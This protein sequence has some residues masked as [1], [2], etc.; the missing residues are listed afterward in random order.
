MDELTQ[1]ARRIVRNRLGS[2]LEEKASDALV[3]Q[4]ASQISSPALAGVESV[5]PLAGS[6]I[7]LRREQEIHEEVRDV[8]EH[9]RHRSGFPQMRELLEQF[10]DLP[11][12]GER[13]IGGLVRQQEIRRAKQRFFA[14]SAPIRQRLEEVVSRSPSQERSGNEPVTEACWLNQTVR[15]VGAGPALAEIAGAEEVG[16][17]DLPR[18]LSAEI[19]ATASV[20]GAPVGHGRGTTGAGLLVAVIDGEVAVGHPAL[21][22]RVVQRGNYTREPWGSPNGHGTAVAGII[23]SGDAGHRGIAPGVTIYNYKVLATHSWL[24]TDDF[25]GALA[26]QQALEDGVHIANCS[27]GAGPA[28][29]GT[30]REARACDNAWALGLTLVKSAGNRGPHPGTLTTPADA[31]GTIVVGACNR[32]GRGVEDYSSRGPTA[33]GRERPHVVAPGGDSNPFSGIVSCVGSGGF[34]DSGIGTSFAAPHVTGLLAL[35]LEENPS[36]DPDGLRQALFA[37][38]RQQAG[39]GPNDQGQGLAVFA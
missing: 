25:G 28:G 24:N 17:L 5:A 10:E 27:W 15:A 3:L 18:R 7:E 8:E 36:L 30:S 35:L 23:A 13:L 29:D 21:Q 14:T 12:T 4:L 1:E 38:C 22:G 19:H 33:D 11:E 39:F 2:A 31:E 34:G 20:V 26:I 32:A 16:R 6:I 9:L 37:L